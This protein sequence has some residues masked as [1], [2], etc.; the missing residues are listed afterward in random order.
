MPRRP[1]III[2][3]VPHHV[4]QRGNNRQDVFRSAEDR[5]VYLKILDA[6]ARGHGVRILAWCLMTNH[7]H[8]VLVPDDAGSLARVLGQ[9]HS[10]YALAFNR[11]KDRVGHLWQN[12]FFSC[13]LDGSHL[14][15][16]VR[17]VELNPVRAGL[18]GVAWEW[19]WSS[20]LAHVGAS[21]T[22]PLLDP[23][24]ADSFPD[25]DYTGWKEYL[26][27]G[28]TVEELGAIRRATSV[29][30][31]LGSAEFLDNLERLAGKRLRVLARGRPKKASK[32]APDERTV[33]RPLFSEA[34]S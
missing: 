23:A 19:P 7:V 17:Y 22:D 32:Q 30:E 27:P 26:E 28:L 18:I 2:P 11:E 21:A 12:R 1:R 24:W 25:W 15:N 34:A 6:E 10:R 3:G 13:A 4:T 16:A 9:T 20:A 31:P 29:G 8:L 14:L 5:R 33:Q